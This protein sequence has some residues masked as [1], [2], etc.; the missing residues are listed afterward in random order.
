MAV[1]IGVGFGGWPFATLQPELLWDYAQRCE[2]LGIDSLWLSDRIV[3]EKFNIEPLIA[4]ATMAS[5]TKN[6]KFGTSVLALPLRNPTI[7]AKQIASI[8][9]LS[10]GRLLPAIGLGSENDRE[11]E[12]CGTHRSVR[13]G[14]T[15]EAI[16]IMRL[17]WSQDNVNFQGKY[18]SLRDVSIQPKPVQK[19][20]PPIWIGGRSDAALKRTARIG[21]GWL[22]SQASALDVK[23][24]INKIKEYTKQYR[25]SGEIDDDHY[26]A[27]LNFCFA[28]SFN[29]AEL[30]ASPYLVRSR[31]DSDYRRFSIL[32]RPENARILIDSFIKAGATKFIARPC[33][34][35]EMMLEQ[36]EI[37]GQSI[38]PYYH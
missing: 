35:P 27:I 33:C 23:R 5:Y 16:K 8:D 36:L 28:D 7:L 24:G 18:F 21:D 30:L 22:V 1:R 11:Y 12:S 29:E 31:Q 9:F 15:D 14:Q 17:L 34:P 19:D 6:L 13:S 26:G 37:L 3:S 25:R 38:L 32:G 10:N 2:T 4:I 20:L